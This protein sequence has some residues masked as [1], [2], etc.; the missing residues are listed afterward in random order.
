MI[1][2]LKDIF[3]NIPILILLATI[4]PNVLEYIYISLKLFPLLCIYKRS[5]NQSNL[6]YIVLLIK[7][8]GFE[9]LAFA[10][11]S[12]GAV[13]NIPKTMIFVNLIDNAVAIT[14]YLHLKLL[15]Q[16]KTTGR[17]D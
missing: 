15:W 17:L 12:S 6:I 3:S 5:L 11:P 9:D 8:P 7:K 10:I 4:T 14:K 13:R 2:Y 16:K 1:G